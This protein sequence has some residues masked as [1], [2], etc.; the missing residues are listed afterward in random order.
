MYVTDKKGLKIISAGIGV[1]GHFVPVF[2]YDNWMQRVCVM[3]II[4]G[5]TYW[6]FTQGKDWM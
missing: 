2:Q 5:F 1:L 4:A 6:R 3:A